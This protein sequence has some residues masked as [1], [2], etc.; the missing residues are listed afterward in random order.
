MAAKKLVTIIV[1]CYNVESYID[2]CMNSVVN[3]TIGIDKL[4]IILVDDASTDGTLSKIQRWESMYPDDI[5]IVCCEENR[6]QGAARNIG[7]QF[8]TTEYVMYI[9]ADDW[10]E[11]S[12]LEKMYHTIETT[13]V[14]LVGA[15]SGRDWG[16]GKFCYTTAYPGEMDTVVRIQTVEERQ[17]LL[18]HGLGDGVWAK[19]YRKYFLLE[20]HLYFPEKLT[21]ED[22]Y[23]EMLL[24]MTVKSYVILSERYYHYFF[25]RHS[26][27]STGDSAHQF[28]RL[29]VAILTDEEL[30]R[31][32]Y[33]KEYADEI[34]IHFLNIF[35]INTLHIIFTRFQTLPYEILQ[36]MQQ[37]V[38][39]RYP[40]CRQDSASRKMGEIENIML[41]TLARS[42][43]PEEWEEIAT[44]YREYYQ[45][46]EEAYQEYCQAL[47]DA[48]RE[49]HS[50]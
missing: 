18:A 33:D 24:K 32:G 36:E 34:E 47:E 35:Y 31:R 49:E 50:S 25:N 44:A 48:Y 1:P 4:E 43:H 39:R 28:D 6:R 7:L 26:T 9:D 41:S 27:V 23:F 13:N 30:K 16:D 15:Q 12:M 46:W 10:V 38:L 40:N 2:R 29:K 21:Y 37:E 17:K 11:L 22:N 14:D 8:S 20:N 19:I 5:L 42:L 3:Q 45:K